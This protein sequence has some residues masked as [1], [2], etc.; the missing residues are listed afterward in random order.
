[1]LMTYRTDTI[2]GWVV[3]ALGILQICNLDFT[4]DHQ[5]VTA[6]DI[7]MNPTEFVEDTERWERS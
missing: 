4:L 5:N 6:T 2:F 7:A 1:M 3:H